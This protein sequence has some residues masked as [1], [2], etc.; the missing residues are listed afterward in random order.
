MFGGRFSLQIDECTDVSGDAQLLAFVRYSFEG[1]MHE[2]MLFCSSMEGTC[3]GR[4]IFNKLNS[5]IQK[6]GLRE[7]LD[8]SRVRS[9][10]ICRIKW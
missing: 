8:V 10:E 3:T 9:S 5:N 7:F 4:D 2:D 6:E 1:K